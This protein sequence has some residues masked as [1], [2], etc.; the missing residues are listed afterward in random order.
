MKNNLDSLNDHL[1]ALLEQVSEETDQEGRPLDP[2]MLK[3]RIQRAGA[4]TAIAREIINA[5]RLALDAARLR[6]EEPDVRIPRV[7][8][9]DEPPATPLLRQVR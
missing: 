2:E 4:G 9:S 6:S 8:A 1:F 3:Q 7:I 5:Q